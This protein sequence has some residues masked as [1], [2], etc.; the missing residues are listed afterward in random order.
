MKTKAALVLI[1]EI[2]STLEELIKNLLIHEYN[3]YIHADKKMVNFDTKLRERYRQIKVFQE[4]PIFWGG[5]NMIQAMLF[6]LN[7]AWEAQENQNFIF[8]SG[9]DCMNPKIKDHILKLHKRR[10]RQAIKNNI[11]NRA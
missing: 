7:R 2:N 9:G 10:V 5:F 6:L 11:I 4:Y 3:V 1:H 8:L